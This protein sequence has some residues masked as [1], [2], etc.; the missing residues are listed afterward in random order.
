M[1]TLGTV[2][3]SDDLILEGLENAPLIAY[4]QR[5][6]LAGESVVQVAPVLGGRELAL[7]G[8]N[9]FTLAEIEAVRALAEAGQPVTLTHHRGTFRVLVV[10]IETDP[11]VDHADPRPD[12]WYAGRIN[13]IE[14]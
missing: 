14:V 6:T 7:V 1:T 5:R 10:S 12:D 9:H 11:A 2:T 8:D 13:M 3:L 4:S